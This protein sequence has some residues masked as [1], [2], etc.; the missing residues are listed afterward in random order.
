MLE[1]GFYG[2]SRSNNGIRWIR[3]HKPYNASTLGLNQIQGGLGQGQTLGRRKGGIYIVTGPVLGT[4]DISIHKSHSFP[5]G[6]YG[7]GDNNSITQEVSSNQGYGS[8]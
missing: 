2:Q 3:R 1:V 5:Q 8:T 4:K 6:T 7:L